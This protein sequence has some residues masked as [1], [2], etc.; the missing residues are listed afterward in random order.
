[1]LADPK[2]Y[3]FWDKIILMEEVKLEK[4]L[5]RQKTDD[6]TIFKIKVQPGAGK[7]EIVGVQGDASKIKINAPPVK[8]KANRALID[9][10]ADKL[11]VKRSEVEIISRR[12]SR[13]KKIKVVGEGTRTKDNIQDLPGISTPDDR[14][15]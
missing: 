1:M 12:T 2:K 8:G 15:R 14:R 6:G 3:H 4:K 13:I 11:G 7:N 10:L 5:S 9:F